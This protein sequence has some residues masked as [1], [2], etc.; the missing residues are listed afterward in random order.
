[1]ANLFDREGSLAGKGSEMKGE[2]MTMK[3]MGAI[4]SFT[5][6]VGWTCLEKAQD[7]LAQ[8]ESNE[9]E[10][11]D[12]AVI[13]TTTL[14]P[15]SGRH[16]RRRHCRFRKPRSWAMLSRM[17]RVHG[18]RERQHRDV[19]PIRATTIYS[20]EAQRRDWT[21]GAAQALVIWVL[22][23]TSCACGGADGRGRRSASQRPRAGIR[24]STKWV[25]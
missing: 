25:R 14:R 9:G 2:K 12:G 23:S 7:L 10:R 8:K 3:R 20:G 21:R 15:N 13:S 6:L 22:Q 1:M 4:A 16:L 19:L 17:S 5:F 11:I 24:I 18:I